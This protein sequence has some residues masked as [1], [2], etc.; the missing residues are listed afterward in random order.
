V[1]NASSDARVEVKAYVS[2][3]CAEREK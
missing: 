3:F 2:M 1:E